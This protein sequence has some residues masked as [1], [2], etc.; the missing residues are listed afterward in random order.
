MSIISFLMAR[1][2]FAWVSGPQAKRTSPNG[3]EGGNNRPTDYTAVLKPMKVC[4]IQQR[5][6]MFGRAPP[7]LWASIRPLVAE[8]HAQRALILPT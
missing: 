2:Q 3:A 4:C 7:T 5:R 1:A 6:A 8:R